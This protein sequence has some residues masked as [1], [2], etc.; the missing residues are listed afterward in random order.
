MVETKTTENVLKGTQN[1]ELADIHFK[2]AILN[3]MK[4][5]KTTMPKELKETMKM[6]SCQIEKYKLY[7]KQIV[8]IYLIKTEI[9][10]LK[11]Q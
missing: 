5:L 11:L 9:L 7:T 1:L 2:S 10:E 8:I 3:M 4:E 6:I